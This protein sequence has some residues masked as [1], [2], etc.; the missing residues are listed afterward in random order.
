MKVLHLNLPPVPVELARERLAPLGAELVVAET[1]EGDD[2]L[3]VAH[4]VDAI[5]TAGVGRLLTPEL[6]AGLER[7]RHVSLWSGSTDSI[8]LAPFTEHRICVSFAA[9]ACTDEVA[10]HGMAMMLALGRK[11]FHFDRVMRERDGIYVPHDPIIDEAK[12]MPRLSTLTV[13]SIGF[14]RA[15][16]A[17]ATRTKGFG[18]RFLAYDPFIPP[19]TGADL[20]V[21]L[22]TMERVLAESDFLHLYV[23]MKE[24]TFHLI[25]TEQLRQMKPTAYLVNVSARSAVID[26]TALLAA[27]TDG[28]IAGAGLDNLDMPEG[29]DLEKGVATGAANPILALDNVILSPHISHVSDDSYRTMQHRVCDDVVGFFNGQWPAL[30]ANPAVKELI[31]TPPG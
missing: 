28:T 15:G 31:G 1:R 22:T 14:G 20:G 2:F 10:D 17:L 29:I 6:I 9:D 3:A 19:G 8:D 26:E 30:V 12:P 16:L 7:C 4:D 5:I 27:L 24:D 21:E 25:G 18:M 23:P 11:L 13:G